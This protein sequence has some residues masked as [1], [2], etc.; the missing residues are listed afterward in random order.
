MSKDFNKVREDRYGVCMRLSTL[1]EQ[2][3][4]TSF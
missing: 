1:K 2:R 3:I 4:C